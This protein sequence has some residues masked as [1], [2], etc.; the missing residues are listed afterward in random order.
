MRLLILDLDK[1]LWSHPDI[2]STNPP[3][4]RVSED[5]I[6]DSHGSLS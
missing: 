2:S 1:T 5:A 6:A 3:Y 4:R